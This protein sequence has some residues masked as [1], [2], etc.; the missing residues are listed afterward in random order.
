MKGGSII[1]DR[2]LVGQQQNSKIHD[3]ED[4]FGFSIMF[5]KQFSL[6]SFPRHE[7]TMSFLS[8]SSQNE[9]NLSYFNLYP[10]EPRPDQ[11]NSFPSSFFGVTG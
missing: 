3:Q 2:L 10:V 11:M 1:I 4:I 5:P 9:N 8:S 7:T 6:C